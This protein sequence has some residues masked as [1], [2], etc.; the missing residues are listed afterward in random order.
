MSLLL[1]IPRV[2]AQ[3]SVCKELEQARAAEIRALERVL[4]SER[5]ASSIAMS[6]L[7]EQ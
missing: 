7:D 6:V 4:A 2:E 3:E 1:P 5:L